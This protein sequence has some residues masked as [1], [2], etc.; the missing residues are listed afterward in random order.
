[1]HNFLSLLL[2]VQINDY[3]LI[4]ILKIVS[5]HI[6]KIIAERWDNGYWMTGIFDAFLNVVCEAIDWSIISCFRWQ[7]LKVSVDGI[8]PS[9]RS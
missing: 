9:S 4:L 2:L 7:W 6:F 1:M 5:C 3:L 8:I